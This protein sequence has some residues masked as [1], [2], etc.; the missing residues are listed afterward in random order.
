MASA[1]VAAQPDLPVDLMEEILLRLDDAADLICASAAC[2]SFH[3]LISDGH[4]I[5]RFKSLQ[6]PP[7][8]GLLASSYGR[9][10]EI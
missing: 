9:D 10:E 4:F 2:T 8:L 7:V 3:L 6:Y 1:A 5:R